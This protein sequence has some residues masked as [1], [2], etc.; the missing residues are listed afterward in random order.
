MAPG[1][2]CA[3]SS[4][5]DDKGTGTTQTYEER[6]AAS[7]KSAPVVVALG[8]VAAAFGVVVAVRPETQVSSGRGSDRVQ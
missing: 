8:V 3:Y 5:T 2:V 1:D 6:V 4:Y 7:R